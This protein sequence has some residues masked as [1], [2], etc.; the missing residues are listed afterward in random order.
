MLVIVEMMPNIHRHFFPIALVSEAQVREV[1]V[2]Y[3]RI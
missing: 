3:Q 2:K 1:R